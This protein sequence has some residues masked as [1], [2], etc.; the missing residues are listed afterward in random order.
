MGIDD[1]VNKGKDFIDQNKDAIDNVVHSEQA[2]GVSD[3][4]LDAGANAAKK[5][6]PDAHD[7]TVGDVRDQIDKAIGNE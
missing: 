7:G 3:A 5:V 2:E 6:V 1:L 4:V